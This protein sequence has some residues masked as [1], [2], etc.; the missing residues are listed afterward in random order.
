MKSGSNRI[1]VIA[2][3]PRRGGNSETLLDKALSAVKAARI[4]KIALSDFNI[5]PCTGCESCHKTGDCVIKDDMQQLYGKFLAA[6]AIVVA[7]PIYFKGLPCQLKCVIDRC[8][9]LWA[10][11][12]VLK[13]KIAP[14]KKPKAGY[15]I[16]V[17]GSEGVNDM[18]TASLI[19]LKAWFATLG[20]VCAGGLCAEGLEHENDAPGNKE[21]LEKAVVF[22]KGIIRA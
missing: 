6:D 3:S 5:K 16:L 14:S 4:D 21:L 11:K 12:H 15:C 9:A 22:G 20:F 18:F 17:S 7:S 19:V 10:R 13:K 2:A 1:L 8:Q